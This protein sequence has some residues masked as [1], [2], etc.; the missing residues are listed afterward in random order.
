MNML[1]LNRCKQLFSNRI[2]RLNVIAPRTISCGNRS[3]NYDNV[4]SIHHRREN[5]LSPNRKQLRQL[6]SEYTAVLKLFSN[7]YSI[8]Y[9]SLVRS[10]HTSQRLSDQNR[11]KNDNNDDKNKKNDD[12]NE[13]MMSVVTKTLLWMITIYM[14]VAFATMIFPSKNRTETTT[15]YVSWNEFVH[16]MLAAG[17]VKE[18]IIHPDMDM[19]TIILHEGAII[20][21]RRVQSNIFHMAVAD[22]TKFEEKLRDVEK[23]LGVSEHVTVSFER[24]SELGGKIL[25]SLVATAVIIALLSRMKGFKGPISMDSFV[26]KIFIYIVWILN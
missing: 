14:F 9:H 17:E 11:N 21:G 16:H 25:F 12:D 6:H 22:V 5:V 7:S 24:T 18:V 26:N 4:R 15:R 8:P 19:V 1:K 13:K 2:H 20:K 3:I 23:K 10:I